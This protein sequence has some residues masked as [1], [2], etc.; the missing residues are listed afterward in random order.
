VKIRDICVDDKRCEYVIY[1][2]LAE[3]VE[4]GVAQKRKQGVY[5]ID[6][7]AVGLV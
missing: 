4:K 3:L 2:F 5:L 6:R 1:T 7:A